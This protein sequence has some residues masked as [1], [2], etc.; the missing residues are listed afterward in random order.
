MWEGEFDLQRQDETDSEADCFE[1]RQKG[2]G[3]QELT[4]TRLMDWTLQLLSL[5]RKK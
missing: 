5:T 3:G 4:L 2:P 1:T